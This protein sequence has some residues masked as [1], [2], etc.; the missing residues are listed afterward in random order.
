MDGTS[1]VV[2]IR[3]ALDAALLELRAVKDPAVPLADAEAPLARSVALLYQALASTHDAAAFRR[4]VADAAQKAE[5]A[6]APLQRSGSKDPAVVRSTASLTDAVQSLARPVSI[7]VGVGLDLPGRKTPPGPVP[8][9]LDEPRLLELQRPVLEPAVP[10][11]PPEGLPAVDEVDP[12]EPAPGGRPTLQALLA[13]ASAA[14][15][16][17]EPSTSPETPAPEPTLPLASPAALEKELLGE[18]LTEDR[19]LFERARHFFEDLGV[20]SL[21]RRPVDGAHWRTPASVERRLLAR[22]DAIV[23]CGT[24][25]FPRLV[26]LL[27]DSPIP[28]AELTWAAVFLHG[29]VNGD[30][31]FDEVL[32]LVRVTDLQDEASFDSVADALRFLPHPRTVPTLEG[33][34]DEEPPLRRLALRALAARGTLRVSEATA[35]IADER[36]ELRREG[37]RT[38]PLAT[39]ALDP[40]VLAQLLRHPEAEVVEGALQAGL[41]RGQPVARATALR[42]VQDGRGDFA[43]AALYA[44]LSASEESRAVFARAWTGPMS[45]LLVEALGWLGDLAAVEPLLA[46]LEA[47]EVA[48]AGAL[49]RLL[50]ASLTETDP[51]PEEPP[52]QPPFREAW[53]PPRPFDVLTARVEPWRTWWKAHAPPPPWR[54]RFRWGRLHSSE[55]LLWEID[56]APLGS[57]ARRLAHLELC[58]R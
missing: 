23:A 53:R 40:G 2:R 18:A 43:R 24:P 36:P 35:A 1:E 22:V 50:G 5:E 37:A 15:G 46:R 54:P 47:K 14:A 44:A 20:M 16:A 13:E 31:M 9:L 34:L 56:G 6:L 30:D 28:D 48:A 21:M 32:R 29:M 42:L 39:G 19:L 4:A 57:D 45:P 52:D 58:L 51:A 55:A 27:A 12:D 8:A 49:Q 10:L 7:P 38:L 25:M 17:E 26:H 33:W 41:Q 11:A 3:G